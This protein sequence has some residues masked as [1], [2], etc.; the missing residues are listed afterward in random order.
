MQY[1]HL[2][3]KRNGI[4]KCIHLEQYCLKLSLIF[5]TLVWYI[6]LKSTAT[7]IYIKY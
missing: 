5:T 3:P 7:T 2:Y 4:D 6:P 1:Y